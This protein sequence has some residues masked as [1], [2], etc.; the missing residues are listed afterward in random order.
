MT[1]VLTERVNLESLAK[2][3]ECRMNMKAALQ[4]KERSLEQILLL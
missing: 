3:G 2:F 4:A 1:G